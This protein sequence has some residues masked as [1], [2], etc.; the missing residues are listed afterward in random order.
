[1]ATGPPFRAAA[2]AVSSSTCSPAWSRR[3]AFDTDRATETLLVR[4]A[5]GLRSTSPSSARSS[6]R[7]MG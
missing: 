4:L 6:R 3:S 2:R 1:M 7:P 5:W